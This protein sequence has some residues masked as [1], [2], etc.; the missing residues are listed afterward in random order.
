MNL[1]AESKQELFVAAITDG[2][3]AA[4]KTSWDHGFWEGYDADETN[5]KLSRIALMHSELSEALH[6]IRKGLMDDHLPNRSMEI[7]EM[8][9][10]VIRIFDYCGGYNLPLGEVILEKMAYNKGRPFKHGDVT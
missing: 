8:A 9:D 7:C 5:Y 2:C 10:T 4:H 3:N 1:S 6:G